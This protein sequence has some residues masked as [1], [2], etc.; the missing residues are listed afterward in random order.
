MTIAELKQY[1]NICAEIQD[2]EDDL[3]ANHY[4]GDTVQSAKRFPHKNHN[5]HI[6]GYKSD[7]GTVSKLARLAEKK[8]QRDKIDQFVE[9]ITDYKLKKSVKIYYI[10]PIENGEDKPTWEMV[11]DEIGQGVTSYSLK[12]GLKR[13][14][15]K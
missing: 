15:K 10:N 12:A 8:K 11:A 9:S 7:G 1:R 13:I 2:I 14:L 3:N 6:E 4:V 5:V